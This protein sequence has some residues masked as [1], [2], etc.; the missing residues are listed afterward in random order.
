MFKKMSEIAHCRCCGYPG[1]LKEFD[2]VHF[3]IFVQMVN[4]TL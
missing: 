1:E 3:L 4:A 2:D